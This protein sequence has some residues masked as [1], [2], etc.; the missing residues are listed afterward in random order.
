MD[1]YTLYTIYKIAYIVW[2]IFI[3]IFAFHTFLVPKIKQA[4]IRK[5]LKSIE[6]EE[7]MLWS[8]F[9]KGLINTVYISSSSELLLK[10]EIIQILYNYDIERDT[11][12]ITYENSKG[13]PMA[14]ITYKNKETK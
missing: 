9:K 4:I 3:L 14:C 1:L 13:H 11:L 7:A 12:D 2:T 10:N 6:K 8:D 5:K